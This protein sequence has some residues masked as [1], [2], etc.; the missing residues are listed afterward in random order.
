MPW[1]DLLNWDFLLPKITEKQWEEI[2]Q[3]SQ[4][5]QTGELSKH[6]DY[7]KA[8]KDYKKNMNKVR[9]MKTMSNYLT[10]SNVLDMMKKYKQ[11]NLRFRRM[12]WNGKDMY[13]TLQ[14]PD[15]NS[16]MTQ[17]YIYMKTADGNLVPWVASQTDLLSEDW[18][19]LPESPKEPIIYDE[20]KAD[21]E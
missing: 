1:G 5:K 6:D 15:E 12:G 9:Y 19:Q 14:C 3:Q 10:F 16:K 2:L 8:V 18:V 4:P 21:E 7:V 13:I 11:D 20:I 17:S